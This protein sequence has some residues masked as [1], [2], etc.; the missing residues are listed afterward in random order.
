MKCDGEGEMQ[1]VNEEGAIHETS[2][3]KVWDVLFA[4]AIF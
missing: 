1:A 3:V 2:S 4:D